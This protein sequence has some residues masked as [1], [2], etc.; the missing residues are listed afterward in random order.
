VTDRGGA[1]CHAAIVTRE[2]GIPGV[3]GT[4]D[5]TQRIEDGDRIRVD[6]DSGVV[7]ILS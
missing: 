5:G 6:G 4:R 2:F 7:T 1:L 3:V